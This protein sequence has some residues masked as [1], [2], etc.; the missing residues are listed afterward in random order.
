MSLS[1]VPDYILYSIMFS[2]VLSMFAGCP[3]DF[4]ISVETSLFPALI[5][6][7][8]PGSQLYC[9]F[10]DS[11][12]SWLIHPYALFAWSFGKRTISR[13][14]PL[15]C[16]FKGLIPTLKLDLCCNLDIVRATAAWTTAGWTTKDLSVQAPYQSEVSKNSQKYWVNLT[17]WYMS[18]R[19]GM[20]S[21]PKL[22]S[23]Q[24]IKGGMSIALPTG[25]GI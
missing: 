22:P 2:I 6:W 23:H 3:K 1:C 14:D 4:S 16:Q 11:E 25:V 18:F 5:I 9:V 8:W 21:R 12:A 24:P 20:V 15:V 17:P 10:R 13:K 7:Y 19:L